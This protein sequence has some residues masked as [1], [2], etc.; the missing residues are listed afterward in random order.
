MRDREER[1]ECRISVSRYV[2]GGVSRFLREEAMDVRIWVSSGSLR[3]YG[4]FGG[5]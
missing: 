3:E 2:N 5:S 1:G 4:R